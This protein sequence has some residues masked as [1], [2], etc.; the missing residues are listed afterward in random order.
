MNL[1]S[2][3]F[4]AIASVFGAL[5]VG[6]GAFGAHALKTQLVAAGRLDTYHTAVLYQFIHTLA[7]FI[8][9]LLINSIANKWFV[10]AAWSFAA[11]IVIFCGSLYVLCLSGITILGAITPIGGVL[12]ILGWIFL[13]LGVAKK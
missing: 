2:K 9:A 1:E 12:F 13:L 6:L 4:I 7:I 11:G 8:T 3:K 10:R 5:A